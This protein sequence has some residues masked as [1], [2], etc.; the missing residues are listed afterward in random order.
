MVASRRQHRIRFVSVR[1]LS[2]PTTRPQSVAYGAA[3]ADLVA[4]RVPIRAGESDLSVR[5]RVV[6]A[7]A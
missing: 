6:W 5:V 4:G 1:E 2:A 3:A 7:L